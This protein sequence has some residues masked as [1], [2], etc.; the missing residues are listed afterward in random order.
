MPKTNLRAKL[1]KI[2]TKPK[3][4]AIT[5]NLIVLVITLLL[6]LFILEVSLR[7]T[8]TCSV[9]PNKSGNLFTILQQSKNSNIVYELK[10][11]SK[12]YL[13]GQFIEINEHGMKSPSISK[14]KP[15]DLYRIAFLG[16]SITF[17]WALPFSDSFPEQLKSKIPKAEIL[18]FAVPGYVGIQNLETLKT[19]VL[20]FNPDLII[21]GHFLN[22]P[23]GIWQV[24]DTTLNIPTPIKIF[25]N[26]NSCTYNWAK[27]RRNRIL[28]RAGVIT[29][30]PYED[31]YEIKSESWQ[32]HKK[33]FEKMA[34]ISKDNNIPI[35]VVIL[36]NWHNLN[37]D[38]DFIGIHSLLNKTITQAGLHSIDMYTELKALNINAE[39]FRIEHVHPNAKGHK[40][41]AESIDKYIQ[42]N[43]LLP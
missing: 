19:K 39:D 26:E 16:D 2:S 41:I 11:N 20:D 8:N 9:S 33:L 7:L 29:N 27:T 1:W 31:L 35:L 18:N 14:E 23:D 6:F 10:P 5:I 42:E 28:N 12:G 22:D 43:Y 13:N 36:P 15:E 32:N 38:Y 24:Y 37:D 25:L 4:K 34:T 17:G 21:M 30:S 3:V 40:L